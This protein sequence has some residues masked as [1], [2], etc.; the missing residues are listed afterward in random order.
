MF[1]G[2][3]QCN[4]TN[5][6]QEKKCSFWTNDEGVQKLM[7]RSEKH[8]STFPDDIHDLDKEQD[9][10]WYICSV[11][12]WNVTAYVKKTADLLKQLP[13]AT[14]CIIPVL[15]VLPHE[16]G[17]HAIT[18]TYINDDGEIF[19]NVL[20]FDKPQWFVCVPF[21]TKSDIIRLL[22]LEDVV[23][24][25]P[26]TSPI[27][28]I[29]KM[30]QVNWPNWFTKYKLYDSS[31]SSQLWSLRTGI[32]VMCRAFLHRTLGLSQSVG[33]GQLIA[34]YLQYSCTRQQKQCAVQAETRNALMYRVRVLTHI[35]TSRL[36]KGQ[37]T[38]PFVDAYMDT[39]LS[40]L[41]VLKSVHSKSSEVVDHTRAFV[42]ALEGLRISHQEEQNNIGP[43]FLKLLHLSLDKLNKSSEH[44]IPV[45]EAGIKELCML[46]LA[47][48][49]GLKCDQPMDN[50]R[51]ESIVPV[52]EPEVIA[53]CR[54]LGD[55]CRS[56]RQRTHIYHPVF[57]LNFLL[58]HIFAQLEPVGRKTHNKKKAFL[59]AAKSIMNKKLFGVLPSQSL[60]NW[61]NHTIDSEREDTAVH[62]AIPYQCP[63]N[64][65]QNGEESFV[66]SIEAEKKRWNAWITQS[67]FVP[68]LT[69]SDTPITAQAEE[70]HSP[71]TV[72]IHHL[73]TLPIPEVSS[74]WAKEDSSQIT[75]DTV[76]EQVSL[77]DLNPPLP[78]ELLATLD[79]EAVDD[80]NEHKLSDREANIPPPLP[81]LLPT[82]SDTDAIVDN[83]EKQLSDRV[84]N[85]SHPLPDNDEQQF[86]DMVSNMPPPLPA[87][88]PT[89]LDTDAIGDNN[90]EQLSDRVPNVPP[91]LPAQQP[92]TLDTNAIGDNN[93]QQL[94]DRVSNV[95][96]PLPAQLSGNDAI[97]DN[98]GQ[99]LAAISTTLFAGTVRE[100][101]EVDLE[102]TNCPGKE[103]EQPESHP[104]HLQSNILEVCGLELHSTNQ[105][106]THTTSLPS[107]ADVDATIARARE[108]LLNTVCEYSPGYSSGSDISSSSSGSG[109][110]GSGSSGSGSSGSDTSDTEH[111]SEA[112]PSRSCDGDSTNKKHNHTRYKHTGKTLQ[113][114]GLPNN[115][116]RNRHER[117]NT[118]LQERPQQQQQGEHIT[119]H[120]LNPQQQRIH[121]NVDQYDLDNEA[122]QGIH[123]ST[124]YH[125]RP[126]RLASQGPSIHP[127]RRQYI[128]QD[129]CYTV[130]PNQREAHPVK[131]HQ[132]KRKLTVETTRM[133]RFK[134]MRSKRPRR[135]IPA[136]TVG[137]SSTV[138]THLHHERQDWCNSRRKNRIDSS[139]PYR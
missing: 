29:S 78:A 18:T 24:S 118:T 13:A 70:Q 47:L 19:P 120:V 111:D 49:S 33:C 14:P 105:V 68:R 129:P 11:Q 128:A 12:P 75:K 53:C 108:D 63:R 88:Q 100:A 28:P 77:N 102:Y 131:V 122:H 17:T 81:A 35:Y 124:H 97:G 27:V 121:N 139:R 138:N 135:R 126:T 79:T 92:T 50:I 112:K 55:M 132:K 67:S 46:N 44:D 114:Q 52:L 32:N 66:M 30:L 116:T 115:G 65:K 20:H 87:Q 64:G 10:T 95:P 73:V 25:L 103:P 15:T 91:P 9:R 71:G 38:T 136:Q 125:D 37:F 84:P 98:N 23:G 45:N 127:Q 85:M 41:A 34:E 72:D 106:A 93:E 16:M 39:M 109:S 104:S 60:F 36:D 31:N 133:A 86:L 26:K 69:S 137:R 5:E 134:I 4:T 54:Y 94:S 74:T 42:T 107:M 113:R 62:F 119:G 21:R 90:E 99:R 56:E 89:T 58:L 130:S 1:C 59:G 110:S 43:K 76:H 101:E 3:T 82:T 51:D 57:K 96:P 6:Q 7:T 8:L 61:F 48:L 80:N 83:D 123:Y 40:M 2:F 22:G 117:G